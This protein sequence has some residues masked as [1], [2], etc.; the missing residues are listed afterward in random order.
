MHLLVTGAS[1]FIGI[2]LVRELAARGHTGIAASRRPIAHLPRGW[3][4]VGRD[5]LLQGREKALSGVGC[6]SLQSCSPAGAGAVPEAVIHLEVKQHVFN[7]TPQD[8]EEF[9]TVNVE[10][11]GA[12]LQWCG[13]MAIDRFVL[14]S[15]IKA[16]ALGVPRRTAIT[17][18]M[19][20]D[21]VPSTAY[22]RSKRE[23]EN[24]V[25]KWACGQDTISDG[26][27]R[28]PRRAL[29]LRPAVVYGPE[30]GANIF[31]MVDAIHRGRFVLVG[32]NDNIKSLISIRNLTAAV[33]FLVG[34]MSVGCDM[35]YLTD[36]DRMSVEQLAGMIA[37]IQGGKRR[38]RRIPH[39]V[40]GFL[41]ALGDVVTRLPGGRFPITS[42]RLRALI[43]ETNFSCEKL[44]S[45]GFVHPQTVRD[46]LGEMVG[47]YLARRSG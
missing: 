22:G 44:V 47:W 25:W 27:S 34:R 8:E 2:A 30:N 26:A 31:A 38:I 24:L 23:A 20:D 9:T 28:P 17:E 14:L 39:W 41:A 42:D 1:G 12:W 43:E 35:F 3:T 37:A 46:G 19:V 36:A 5:R 21:S 10:G 16:T 29:V 4:W 33:E 13:A 15:T 11:T 18:T 6:S 40:A 32:A 45:R 7:P